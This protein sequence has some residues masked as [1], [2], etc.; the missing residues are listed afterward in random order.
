MRVMRTTGILFF[1]LFLLVLPGEGR[2]IFPLEEVEKGLLGVG[3]TV[4]S[5]QK[6]ET[7]EVEV[8][9]VLQ[10]HPPVDHL[11]LIRVQGD[12][13]EEG[14]GIAAGMSGSPVYVQDKILGAIGYGWTL[15]DHRLGLVTPIEAMLSLWEEKTQLQL[16]EDYRDWEDFQVELEGWAEEKHQLVPVKTPLF[17]SG[18]GQRGFT[19]LQ[20]KL[21]DYH[22]HFLSGG[23]L[24]ER[25]KEGELIPGSAIAIQLARGDINVSAMGTLSY[26]DGNRIL[27]LGHPFL[28]AGG[29][30][31]L[32]SGAYIHRVIDS[33]DMPFKLGSPTQLQGTIL[34]DRS[35]GVTGELYRYPS[36]VPLR[37]SVL[38]KD[39]DQFLRTNV[40]LVR[41][42]EF[43]LNLT[44]ISALE[45]ID[46]AVD[47]IG[48]GTAEVRIELTA[49]GLPD[50]VLVRENIFNSQMDIASVAIMEL[51]QI[52]NLLTF[53]PFRDV[54]FIDI[55][56]DVEVTRE[57][58]MAT[59]KE[60]NVQNEEIYPGDELEILVT[61]Q[62]YRQEEEELLLTVQLPEDVNEGTAT[63]SVLSGYEAGYDQDHYKDFEEISGH[64]ITADYKNLE[65]ML[66]TFLEQPM[67]NEI[68]IEIW[69]QYRGPVVEEDGEVVEEPPN[70]R[71]WEHQE[72]P[73]Y[74]AGNLSTT[75]EILP[76]PVEDSLDEDVLKELE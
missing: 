28:F 35:A 39:R 18:M 30:G 7:F 36:V 17:V 9:G 8:L 50:K 64:A 31:Y 6:V 38:D 44:L 70:E 73:Y 62:P 24:M 60:I 47:R 75:L 11:I 16:F 40:Q 1:I 5:G 3:K 45:A 12:N 53:N 42:E 66:T 65:E 23:G 63:L 41:E 59:I 25:E 49:H 58:L 71:I 29:G 20:E 51:G 68:F 19:L 26:R 57:L 10:H 52:L 22:F 21:P 46:R 34:T 43:L 74:L 67:N 14:G 54:E 2:E 72:T 76:L 56:L 4:F 61:L 55:R 33:L 48:R 32:L 13:I 15:T 27:G 69:P 37:I